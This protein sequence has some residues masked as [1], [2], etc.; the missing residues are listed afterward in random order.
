MGQTHQPHTQAVGLPVC[1]IGQHALVRQ[2]LQKAVE[3]GLGIGAVRQQFG[4]AH[5]PTGLG[6]PVQHIK[7]LAH[8]S[9]AAAVHARHPVLPSLLTGQTIRRIVFNIQD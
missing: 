9:I 1:I 4:K 3:R 6:D 7:R 2:G 5:R 8:C